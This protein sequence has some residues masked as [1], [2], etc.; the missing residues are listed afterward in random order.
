MLKLNLDTLRVYSKGPMNVETNFL[1]DARIYAVLD[2]P[3][4]WQVFAV[5]GAGDR[6]EGSADFRCDCRCRMAGG[7]RRTDILR[8]WNNF[9]VLLLLL[10][11]LLLDSVVATLIRIPVLPMMRDIVSRRTERLLRNTN[12]DDGFIN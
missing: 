5:F 12:G 2:G 10:L 1:R 11:L 3:S 4:F 6:V 8:N 9:L 7:V